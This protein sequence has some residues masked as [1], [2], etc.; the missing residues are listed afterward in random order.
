MRTLYVAMS[1]ALVWCGCSTGSRVGDDSADGLPARTDLSPG[2]YDSGLVVGDGVGVDCR[3]NF[4]NVKGTVNEE[5]VDFSAVVDLGPAPFTV[6]EAGKSV[7]EVATL[8]GGLLSL[9]VDPSGVTAGF[10]RNA[11]ILV[12]S[13]GS[14]SHTVILCERFVRFEFH[15]L[16]AGVECSGQSIQGELVGCVDLLAAVPLIGNDAGR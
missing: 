2:C 7:F 5:A 8:D 10:I 13:C 1:V 9:I 4:L 16:V 6:N 3:E 11:E 15:S 14:D 12:S